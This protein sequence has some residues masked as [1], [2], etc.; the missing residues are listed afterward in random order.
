M[1]S[2]RVKVELRWR[3]PAQATQPGVHAVGESM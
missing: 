1:D 2:L 3:G